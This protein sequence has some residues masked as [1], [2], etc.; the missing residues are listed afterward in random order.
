MRCNPTSASAL[1]L[2]LLSCV[3]ARKAPVL[4]PPA[5]EIVTPCRQALRIQLPPVQVSRFEQRK[6]E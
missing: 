2:F 4:A 6:P 5:E 1:W 3:A